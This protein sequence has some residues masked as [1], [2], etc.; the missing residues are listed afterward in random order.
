MDYLDK[1]ITINDHLFIDKNIIKFDFTSY[2]VSD[3][4][5]NIN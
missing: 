3:N 4:D 2:L 1:C 5:I